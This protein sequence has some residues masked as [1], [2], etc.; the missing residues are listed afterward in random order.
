MPCTVPFLP[1]RCLA[2]EASTLARQL[3]IYAV[4][5]ADNKAFLD[6]VID[7]GGWGELQDRRRLRMTIETV[8]MLS[9]TSV[10]RSDDPESL[11][12]PD[13][14]DPELQWD[15]TSQT[16]HG[17][18]YWSGVRSDGGIIGAHLSSLLERLN[19]CSLL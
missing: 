3:T 8:G 18:W 6:F 13:N 4:V 1:R 17:A 12:P 14:L 19:G 16:A 10:L 15:A 9:E 2:P 11:D 7:E 5:G